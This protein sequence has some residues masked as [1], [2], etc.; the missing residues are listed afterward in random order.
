MGMGVGETQFLEELPHARKV[1]NMNKYNLEPW[2]A[3]S[4]VYMHQARQPRAAKQCSKSHSKV[5]PESEFEPTAAE[6]E[7][8][9]MHMPYAVNSS[10]FWFWEGRTHGEWSWN[11]IY[12]ER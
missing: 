9:T 12:F 11:M 2:E 4:I 5:D 7:E 6:K 3:N 10:L 8:T 1:K